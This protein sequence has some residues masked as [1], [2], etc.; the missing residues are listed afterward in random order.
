MRR[1]LLLISVVTAAM[2]GL[3]ASASAKGW[4]CEASALRAQVLEGPD[5]RLVRRRA[6]ERTPA[7]VAPEHLA[8][9]AL[10]DA[11]VGVVALGVE[12]RRHARAEPLVFVGRGHERTPTG[13]VDYKTLRSGGADVDDATLDARSAAVA[14]R[15]FRARRF[16]HV[17]RRWHRRCG[18]GRRRG[19]D[20][21]STRRS[22]AAAEAHRLTD[23]Q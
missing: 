22:V 5:A 14:R 2:A 18:I 7:H 13:F 19:Q 10:H 11:V 4:V 6:V 23:L 20:R 8:V 16:G 12:D 3:T 21:C 17:V 1:A 15:V 9:G